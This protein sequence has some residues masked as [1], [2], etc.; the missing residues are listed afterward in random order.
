[1]VLTLEAFWTM[2]EERDLSEI[3]FLLYGRGKLAENKHS[4]CL[5][6]Q[7]L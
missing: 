6:E 4:Q 2:L 3:H 7:M 5:L 1:M